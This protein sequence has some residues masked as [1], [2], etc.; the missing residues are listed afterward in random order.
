MVSSAATHLIADSESCVY[1][2]MYLEVDRASTI[3]TITLPKHVLRGWSVPQYCRLPD[4]AEHTPDNLYT[5]E[6]ALLIRLD[7]LFPITSILDT[8]GSL[9]LDRD[10]RWNDQP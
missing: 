9:A 7:Q 10:V 3:R 4:A 5:R 8:A 1:H 6:L 2:S